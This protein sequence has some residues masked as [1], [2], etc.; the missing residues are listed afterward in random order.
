[1]ASTINAST[2]PA[3]IVSSADASGVLQLQ[4]GGTAA[5]TVDASQNVGIGTASPG[6]KLGVLSS[7][8]A[9]GIRVA[10]TYGTNDSGFYFDGSGNAQC[11]MRDSAGNNSYIT[12]TSNNMQFAT[13]GTERMRID[14]SGR[15]LFGIS[16]AYT[17]SGGNMNVQSVNGFTLGNNNGNSTNRI[18]LAGTD[19]NH[20]IYSSGSGG[21]ILYFGSYSTWAFFNSATSSVVATIASN[22]TY[23]GSD[24]ALKSNVVDLQNGLS[25]V[26]QLKPVSYTYTGGL[27]ES[28]EG[29]EIVAKDNCLG[30]IAQDVQEIIPSLIETIDDEKSHLGLNY[31]GL[32]PVLTKAIQELKAI[33]DAQAEQIKAL[34]SK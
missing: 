20:F 24:K 26:L 18:Y 3:G 12:N 2:S 25:N 34:E 32:I 19:A 33:V 22:G 16:S 21:N 14:S 6:S 9:W 23:T 4:T 28:D 1:M 15:A 29:Y 7:T 17:G 13:G 11:V 27:Q 31:V 5:V 30:F 8:N 10:T